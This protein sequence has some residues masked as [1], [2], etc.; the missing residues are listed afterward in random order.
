[1]NDITQRT[2]PHIILPTQSLMRGAVNRITINKQSSK[3]HYLKSSI[4]SPKLNKF[5]ID[6]PQHSTSIISIGESYKDQSKKLHGPPSVLGNKTLSSL[7]IH[8][9]NM[10][11][12][13][14]SSI[15]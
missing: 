2:G 7:P 15:Y 13:K 11:F 5:D 10:S 6:R 3:G 14:F 8:K 12:Q 9:N 1:M 4:E